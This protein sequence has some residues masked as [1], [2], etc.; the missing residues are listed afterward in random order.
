[1]S[2]MGLE[3]RL[4]N[5]YGQRIAWRPQDIQKL[6][7]H[8]KV[9][10]TLLA[11]PEPSIKRAPDIEDIELKA[12]GDDNSRSIFTF[13]AST[14][15]IDRM[16][17]KINQKGW[18]LNSFKRNPVILGFHNSASLPVG[19]A[20]AVAVRDGKLMVDVRFASTGLG[21]TMASMVNDG[22]LKSV[23]V[24]FIPKSFS[25]SNELGRAGGIDFA[26]C[27]LLEVSIVPVP[28]NSACVLH[29]ITA[30]DGTPLLTPKKSQNSN[31]T[32]NLKRRVEVALIKARTQW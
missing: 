21:R 13:I 11:W 18:M 26:S 4:T 9:S 12:K 29:N 24:G 5:K 10:A 15:D 19:K 3:R 22:F 8:Y 31:A 14:S 2:R 16:G 23:S 30:E 27:E 20:V 25:F 6:A 1:M 32:A 7:E 28:A 17:D